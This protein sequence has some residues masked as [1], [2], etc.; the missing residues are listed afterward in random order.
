MQVTDFTPLSAGRLVPAG[1]V[2]AFV[3][4][5]P[6]GD[7]ALDAT[8]IGA[9]SRAA[10]AI[11]ELSGASRRL[12]NPLIYFASLLRKE[13]I[14]SSRIEETHAT[15]DQVALREMGIGEST[16]ESDEVY[17]FVRA[18]EQALKRVNKEGARIDLPML[19]DAHR[20]L[21]KGVRGGREQPGEF[22]MV[23]NWIGTRSGGLREARF[24]PPP[25]QELAPLLKDLERYMNASTE[26]SERDSSA[27]ALPPLVRVAVA[28][29]QFETIH[30]FRDGN[31][32]I[33]RLLVMLLM[34]RDKLLP[35]PVLPISTAI[36]RRK[37]EYMDRMLAVSMRGEWNQWVQFFLDCAADEA[38]EA[39]K[40]VSKLE[41]IRDDWMD[42]VQTTR[43]SA[44]LIK[45]L[46]ALFVRP[47]IT[48][49][50]AGRIMKVTPAA[51][52]A[53]VSR[54]ERLGILTEVTAR[55]R[56]RTY[57]AR[58]IINLLN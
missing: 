38:A 17:N 54:L 27:A 49:G 20:V 32:R 48:I 37:T 35:G 28:H 39:M 56:D 44:R 26:R 13:A 21:M 50:E 34:V 45:V 30:P 24:V 7:L 2:H 22:R 43:A 52:S 55:K 25:P 6:P 41:R 47:V 14:V 15:P 46:D 57:F 12:V 3:P 29:Y 53:N 36:E 4:V 19:L 18:T 40:L 5:P 11:G 23:Q 51:A 10:H 8:T 33:G 42:K 16:P 9:L 58:A 31:G 1:D